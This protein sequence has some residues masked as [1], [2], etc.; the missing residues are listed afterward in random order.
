MNYRSALQGKGEGDLGLTM[1]FL[2]PASLGS[3]SG[4]TLRT[5]HYV[6]AVVIYSRGCNVLSI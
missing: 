4:E 1:P 2:E 5:R 3:G 6:K